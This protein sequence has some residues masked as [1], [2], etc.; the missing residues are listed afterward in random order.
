MPAFGNG[1]FETW[2]EGV[3]GEKCQ[4]IGLLGE[5]RVGAVVVDEGLEAGGPAN[6]V[7]RSRPGM[8]WSTQFELCMRWA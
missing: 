8:R 2:V 6:G 4:D 1:T 5:S 3:T 7:R